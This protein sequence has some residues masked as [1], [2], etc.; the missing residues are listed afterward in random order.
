[1]LLTQNLILA[2]H[3]PGEFASQQ[4]GSVARVAAKEY[5]L[6]KRVVRTRNKVGK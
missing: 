3:K 2:L 6:R 5:N 1:M 4:T